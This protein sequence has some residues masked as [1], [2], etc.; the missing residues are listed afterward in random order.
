MT[1][2]NKLFIARRALREIYKHTQGGMGQLRYYNSITE[3][4]LA[5]TDPAS[6]DA[7]D[8]PETPVS[9][10]TPPGTVWTIGEKNYQTEE[11]GDITVHP[12]CDTE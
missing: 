2:I 8:V 7:V 12:P 6:M 11:D 4:A 9:A 1:H 10:D 5:Q 3:R